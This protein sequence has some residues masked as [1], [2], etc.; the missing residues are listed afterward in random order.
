MNNEEIRT[1][2]DD[3]LTEKVKVE[4]TTLEKL[5][6]AH[7]ISPIENPLKIRSARRL[8]ARLKTEVKARELKG[9]QTQKA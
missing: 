8:V 2:T 9:Q 7:A 5:R 1:L 4:S 6:F 3:E